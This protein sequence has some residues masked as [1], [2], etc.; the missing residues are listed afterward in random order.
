MLGLEL[1]S[2]SKI[3]RD[4]QLWGYQVRVVTDST[5]MKI[6]SFQKK[7]YVLR[8]PYSLIIDQ[9]VMWQSLSE[10]TSLTLNMSWITGATTFMFSIC[11]ERRLNQ[12]NVQFFKVN[13]VKC[14]LVEVTINNLLVTINFLH[15]TAIVF[16]WKWLIQ[17][18]TP[19][20]YCPNSY[21]H[22]SF[23]GLLLMTCLDW[24]YVILK[25]WAILHL[26]SSQGMNWPQILHVG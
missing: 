13:F 7:N 19:I 2:W 1:W 11:V 10:V 16:Q 26:L 24:I 23:L 4:L 25:K 3:D 12:T 17:H 8:L 20:S 21:L 6:S 18:M 14:D 9:Y 22:V 15:N 5:R